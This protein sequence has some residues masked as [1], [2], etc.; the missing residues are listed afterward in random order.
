[1]TFVRRREIRYALVIVAAVMAF[2]PVSSASAATPHP[3]SAPKPTI[4][5]VH[6][7]FA[8]SSSWNAT[9]ASLQLLGFP[10]IAA[11]NPLR[12][13]TSDA[14]YVRALLQTIQGPIVLVG[15][16]YG[17]AVI[18]NAA[19]GVPNVKALVFIAAFLLDDGE[20]AATTPDPQQFPGALVG[21]DTTIA[22]PVP[23]AAAAGGTDV[24]L[25]IKPE[26]FQRVFAADVPRI[27]TNLMAATQR[28]LALTALLQPSGPPAWKTIP[29]WD[30]VALDD[31]AIA[32]AGQQFMA[33]RAHAHTESIHSSHAVMVSHPEAV[34][35]ITLEAARSI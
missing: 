3:S 12:G 14:D 13:L 18:S 10:V 31:K 17:G 16:S 28:P 26:D 5:F 21:P 6:G 32:P 35:R 11:S 9:I 19:R 15:H 34:T 1:M 33:A 22:R 29:S 24:E 27:R 2:L 7:A 30:L 8:D 20:S 23:N 25:T 4:V